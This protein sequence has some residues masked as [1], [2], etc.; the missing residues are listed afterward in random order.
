MR[1]LITFTCYGRHL[2]GSESGSVDLHHNTF[3]SPGLPSNPARTRW[4]SASMSAAPYSMDEIRREIVLNAIHQ[5]SFERDWD[6]LAV[7]VR[8]THVHLVLDSDQE[9]ERVMSILKSRASFALNRRRCDAAG[10][11]RWTRHGSTRYLW[12]EKSVDAAVRYVIEDQGSP[13][14]L[15]QKS[16]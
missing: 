4:E 16:R 2:R 1:Y 14:S 3:G 5:T 11:K 8:S 7:H 10:Q 13:M 12:D 6:L 9:P 15:F